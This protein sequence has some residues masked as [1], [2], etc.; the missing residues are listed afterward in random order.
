MVVFGGIMSSAWKFLEP[1]INSEI[2]TR[3]LKWNREN[4]EVVLAK[5]GSDACVIG[6]VASIYQATISQSTVGVSF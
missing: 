2:S 4:T 5:H 6:G 3:A 1:V